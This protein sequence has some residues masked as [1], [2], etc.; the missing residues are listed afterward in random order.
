MLKLRS[1]V[2]PK[3]QVV[4]PKPIREQYGLESGNIIYFH[5]HD[6]EI[7]L[8]KRDADDILNDL[9]SGEKTKAPKVIDWN[10]LFYSQFE[11]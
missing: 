8:E 3:G 6:G 4:I 10:A 7:M 2:G 1:K 5:A 11:K 9:F